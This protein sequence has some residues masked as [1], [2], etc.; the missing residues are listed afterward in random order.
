MARAQPYNRDIALDAAQDLFWEKGYHATSLKDLEQRLNMKPGS[1]YAAFSNKETLYLL[2]LERYYETSRQDLSDLIARAASPFEALMGHLR[3]LGDG[4]DRPQD[5]RSCML[6]KTMLDT[7]VQEAAIA[8]AARGY[9]DGMRAVFAAA[10]AAA[11]ET[12]EIAGDADVDRLARRF[13]S[14]VSALRIEAHRGTD[15]EALRDLA[16]DFVDGFQSARVA[17]D[18]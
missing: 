18:R 8:K 15:R 3:F 7:T 1:I 11:K 5:A 9:L 12:G 13:Q 17:Q 14:N 16:E 4:R 6:V 2:A 10:F